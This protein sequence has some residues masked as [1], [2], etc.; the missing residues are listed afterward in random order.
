MYGHVIQTYI[1]YGVSKGFSCLE[2]KAL[3]W[4]GKQHYVKYHPEFS[5]Q[6]W[7]ICSKRSKFRFG[8]KLLRNFSTWHVKRSMWNGFGRCSLS[9]LKL[10]LPQWRLE[11]LEYFGIIKR[12][13][14]IIGTLDCRLL[15]IDAGSSWMG[16]GGPLHSWTEENLPACFYFWMCVILFLTFQHGLTYSNYLK[17]IASSRAH[18]LILKHALFLQWSKLPA[19]AVRSLWY[20]MVL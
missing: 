13:N 10:T 3:W 2:V 4:P 20:T 6:V 8:V 15:I 9:K 19:P 1:P 7:E 16:T 18:F 12:E 14:N 17:S 5:F 11:L